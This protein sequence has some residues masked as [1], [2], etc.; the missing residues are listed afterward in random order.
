MRG[1]K[2]TKLLIAPL[3]V[4]PML[5]AGFAIGQSAAVAKTKPPKISCTAVSGNDASG[6]T[7]ESGCSQATGSPP[8]TSLSTP[9]SS[10]TKDCNSVETWT[11]TSTTST[12]SYSAKLTTGSKAESKCGNSQDTILATEK[13]K[14]TAGYGLGGKSKAEVCVNSTT[15]DF[16][17]EPGTVATL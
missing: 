14:I 7:T 6:P 9:Y 12:D 8:A 5:V 2:A 17:L 10:C 15:G 4:A 11:G 13:G 3:L 16:S 1:I